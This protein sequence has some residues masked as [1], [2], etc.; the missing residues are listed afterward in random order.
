[1]DENVWSIRK[2]SGTKKILEHW[3]H[4]LQVSKRLWSRFLQI[5]PKVSDGWL[6][7]DL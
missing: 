3:K 1:M 5:W 6:T 2:Q 4:Q 7:F